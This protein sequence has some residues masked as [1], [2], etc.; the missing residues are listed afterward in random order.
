MTMMETL[1]GYIWYHG[2]A[3]CGDDGNDDDDD[4]HNHNIHL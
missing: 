2:C 1:Y 4:N 3:R